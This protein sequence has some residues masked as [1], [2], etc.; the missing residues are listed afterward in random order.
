MIEGLLKGKS[1]VITGTGSG[2]GRAAAELFAKHGAK[3]I[4][5]DVQDAWLEET[6]AKVKAAGGEAKGVRCD[7]TKR[8]DLEAAVA[9][10]V[11]AYGRLDV[12]YNNAGGATARD[13]N[14]TDIPLDEFWR[15]ISVDLFG[16]FLGCRFA[17]PHLEKAGG[18]SIVNT[19]SIGGMQPSKGNYSYAMSKSSVIMLA[20]SAAI[21]LGEYGIRV[22]CIA[23]A[24]IESP[25]LGN[26]L[27]AGLAD[28]VKEQMMVE[29]RQFLLNRQP[30]QRQGTT[31]DIAEAAMFFASDRSSYI[32]GQ[33]MCVDGGMLTGNPSPSGA[34]QEIVARYRGK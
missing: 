18:G 8:A 34:L 7:V 2:V 23:P 19:T 3:L 15:T 27:G 29:V 30:I 22:N 20:Q 21:D 25:I 33:V 10:A 28:D 17:I 13:G 1:I 16:T 4:C 6:V 12:M 26:M 14:V 5:T 11:E 31:D 24:N 9:A 32:T